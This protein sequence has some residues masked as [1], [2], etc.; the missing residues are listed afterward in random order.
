MAS[1]SLT[2]KASTKQHWSS[3][4]CE[5]PV[6]NIIQG[7]DG[8]LAEMDALDFTG[9]L[10]TCMGG[11]HLHVIGFPHRPKPL[12]VGPD[13]IICHLLRPEF[14]LPV[15]VHCHAG[16]IV[17]LL[18]ASSGHLCLLHKLVKARQEDVV[19]DAR[20]LLSIRVFCRLRWPAT[21]D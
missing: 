11:P 2:Y 16:V 8:Q 21:A 13:E 14:D 9:C 5:S 3:D 20:D 15:L 10:G 18:H 17:C 19:Q 6:L 1:A 4:I 12:I 7:T